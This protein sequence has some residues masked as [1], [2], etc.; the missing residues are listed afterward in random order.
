MK[1]ARVITDGSCVSGRRRERGFGG[2]AAVIEDGS[3]GWVL[4]DRVPDTSSTRMEL[5]AAI[6]GLR[7]LPS[8]KLVELV[9]DCTTIL[10]VHDRWEQG[11]PMKSKDGDLW[12]QL[13]REFE[14]L[15]VKLRLLEKDERMLEHKRAHV[16]AG[17][18]AKA[19]ARGFEGE[20]P[21]P[22][23]KDNVVTKRK[24]I[25]PVQHSR[26]CSPGACIVNC[27]VARHKARLV[28][29]AKLR[30]RAAAQFQARTGEPWKAD[31]W[32]HT[33]YQNG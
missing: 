31:P 7:A 30:E 17:A 16:I 26:G 8:G 4:R 5:V 10:S 6:E 13:A 23:I 12:E 29:E 19:L 11:L 3:D 33:D 20:L 14:R 27:A 2:W 24:V 9:F 1:S 15:R 21:L 22:V 32:R 28:D 25:A 18:E